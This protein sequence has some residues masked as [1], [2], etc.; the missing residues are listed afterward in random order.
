MRPRNKYLLDSGIF[1][2]ILA[3]DANV[4]SYVEEIASGRAEPLVCEVNLAEFYAKTCEK[5]GKEIADIY[6]L[7]MRYQPNMTIIT[8]NDELT[9]N[10]AWLK[11]KHH[12]KV[13]LADCYAAAAAI[14]N[15]AT[16]L[17]TDR[18]LH[19]IAVSEGIKAK[20]FPL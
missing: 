13:S 3:G 1:S 11:C 10:A 14:A 8:P 19:H 18:N 5:K 15:K 7:R 6:Y 16:I 12:D 4:K 2:L 20:V 9:R 17:T